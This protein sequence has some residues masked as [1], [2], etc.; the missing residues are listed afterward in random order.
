MRE[1]GRAARR[2]R[3]FCWACVQG[4]LA[5]SGSEPACPACPLPQ[6]CGVATNLTH[7]GLEMV[8]KWRTAVLQ[9]D[10]L[11]LAYKTPLTNS[12]WAACWPPGLLWPCSRARPGPLLA[13]RALTGRSQL[14]AFPSACWQVLLV[15]GGLPASGAG[16]GVHQG[17]VGCAAQVCR[18]AAAHGAPAHLQHHAQLPGDHAAKGPQAGAGAPPAPGPGAWASR[19]GRGRGR[20]GDAS[21]CQQLLCCAAA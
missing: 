18:L 7:L 10:A 11:R 4:C 9:L 19:Q 16:A 3:C 8:A 15:H 20:P 2:R 6:M 14:T 12:R 13:A 21:A 1:P 17:R 5:C